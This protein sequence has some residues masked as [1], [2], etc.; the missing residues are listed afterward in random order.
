ML[1]CLGAGEAQLRDQAVERGF[2][3]MTRLQSQDGAI[4]DSAGITALAGM[5]YLA[6]GHTPTRGSWRVPSARCLEHVLKAQDPLTGYLGAGYGNMYAHGFATLYL[7]ECYGMS[8]DPRV[9]KALE[10]ALELIYRSQNDEGGW[11]YAPAPV[12]ADLSVTICQVMAIR[13]A[14][15]IGLAGERAGQVMGKAIEYVRMLAN[16]DGSFAYMRGYNFSG[17]GAEA[18]PRTA[19][20]AMSLMGAGYNDPADSHLGPALRFLRNHTAAHLQ[21]QGSYF[22]Y[23][24]YYAAQAMFHSPDEADWRRY[25]DLARPTLLRMQGPDGLWQSSDGHGV[26]Y[27]TA[28]ALIILQIDNNYL[29]IFQR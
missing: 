29:P 22:W 5:A 21:G 27:G 4:G 7:A 25:W 2:E 13:A 1:V 18:V 17:G 19:A 23:G 12:D 9:R 15:N 8:P 20:G 26:A 3:A 11:R 16:G 10:A 24:Q 6:G 14:I 28:M